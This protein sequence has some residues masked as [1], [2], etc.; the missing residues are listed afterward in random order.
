MVL[1]MRNWKEVSEHNEPFP[2]AHNRELD[3]VW[4]YYS[5]KAETVEEIS[6]RIFHYTLSDDEYAKL[7]EAKSG[8]TVRIC[9][10]QFEQ[11]CGSFLPMIRIKLFRTIKIGIWSGTVKVEYGLSHDGNKPKLLLLNFLVPQAAQKKGIATRMFAAHVQAARSLGF[12]QIIA[13]AAGGTSD[14]FRDEEQDTRNGYYT[15]PR[16]GFDKWLTGEEKAR[17][18]PVYAQVSYLR[19]IMEKPEGRTWWSNHGFAL[20]VTF[21]ISPY[22]YSMQRLQ[23]ALDALHQKN[24]HWESGQIMPLRIERGSSLQPRSHWQQ[25]VWEY[26]RNTL[27]T[28]A[29]ASN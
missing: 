16:L 8:E 6:Q 28:H 5:T 3:S 1:Q 14:Q 15:W 26:T 10:S 20:E 13:Y 29:H 9:T 7:I 17:L 21:D 25:P 19:E 18:S 22:S 27:G 24:V 2:V 23:A 4:M 11:S 12:D